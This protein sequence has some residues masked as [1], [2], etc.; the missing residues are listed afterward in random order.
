M[1][2][3]LEHE[4]SNEGLSLNLSP[5]IPGVEAGVTLSGEQSRSKEKKHYTTII[6]ETP[7][8]LDF[9]YHTEARFRLEENPSQLTG[10]PSILTV[11]IL[12]EREDD[13]DF[14]MTPFIDATPNFRL[15]SLFSSI[16]SSRTSDDPIIFSVKEPAVNELDPSV[17]VNQDNLG[18]VNLDHLWG[19]T[20]FNVYGEAVKKLDLSQKL[21]HTESDQNVGM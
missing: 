4:V 7:P 15:M 20:M 18:A 17:S 19:C 13:E 12:L 8:D 6:G 10:I 16:S 14:I 21:E 1:E 3:T 11:A 9:G 2:E 5:G